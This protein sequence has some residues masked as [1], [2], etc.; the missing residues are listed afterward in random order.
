[1]YLLDTN[2]ISEL[3]KLG[4]G[5][6]DARVAAWASDR[7]VVKDRD[8]R[9]VL[10]EDQ[11]L[12]FRG[13]SAGPARLERNGLRNSRGGSVSNFGG[14]VGARSK[15]IGAHYAKGDFSAR[16]PTVIS[17][18]ATLLRSDCSTCSSLR[19]ET[20][21]QLLGL[22][23]MT[24]FLP[25]VVSAQVQRP[26]VVMSGLLLA[27]VESDWTDTVDEAPQMPAFDV[28]GEF[29]MDVGYGVTLAFGYG[30]NPGISAE[31]EAGYRATDV[32]GIENV[33]V[34]FPDKPEISIPGSISARGDLNTLSFMAN[35]YYTFDTKVFRPYVGVGIG[36]A[37]HKATIPSQILSTS[38]GDLL[39]PRYSGD[40]IVFA[41]QLMAGLNWTLA[42]NTEGRAGY[43]YFSTKDGN[44]DG[45]KV[46]Y[47]TH[48]IEA[49]LLIS[50]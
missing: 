14:P 17:T 31:L 47:G 2:V 42:D 4:D 43:R 8:R 1:M 30:A 48:S 38:A 24:L 18:E 36:L 5:R 50:F 35:G 40:D 19:E 37:Q 7:D 20:M 26:Y 33:A 23:L 9:Q 10:V 16:P 21:R 6:A 34:N 15:S 41:Y 3:R 25:A 45:T 46:G 29:E 44:F 13:E 11:Q 22:L 12:G 28:S 49:G 32:S 27:L 39:V